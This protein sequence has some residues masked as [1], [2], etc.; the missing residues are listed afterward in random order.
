[1]SVT[2]NF[3]GMNKLSRAR[4]IIAKRLTK[5]DV[6]YAIRHRLVGVDVVYGKN[7]T[8]DEVRPFL[9]G[10]EPVLISSLTDFDNIFPVAKAEVSYRG[11]T[12]RRRDNRSL[13]GT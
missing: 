1:M 3:F 11:A 6:V 4:D 8:E 10:Q 13:R 7:L 2:H 9:R 5:G 12:Y